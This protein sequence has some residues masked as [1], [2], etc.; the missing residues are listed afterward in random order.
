MPN[1]KAKLARNFHK[2]YTF[3]VSALLTVL[4]VIEQVFQFL[5]EGTFGEVGALGFAAVT[6]L[7]AFLRALPQAEVDE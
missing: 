2:A 6:A 4:L 5:P 7:I 1:L 3:I